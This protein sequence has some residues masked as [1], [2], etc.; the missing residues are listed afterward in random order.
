MYLLTQRPLNFEHDI[1][2]FNLLTWI[3]LICEFSTA[4]ATFS[5]MVRV[6]TQSRSSVI[7]DVLFTSF[8]CFIGV[9]LPQLHVSKQ[10]IV[11]KKKAE[12]TS[13][14]MENN[15]KPNFEDKIIKKCR[16]I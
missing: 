10:A 6:A 16:V 15:N 14:V 7:L 8:F 5:K 12:N 4:A 13:E 3:P 1:S 2:T 11:W 9:A